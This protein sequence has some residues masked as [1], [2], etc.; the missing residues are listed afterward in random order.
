MLTVLHVW[1]RRT[2]NG[3]RD[4]HWA[5]TKQG[6]RS[7]QCVRSLETTDPDRDRMPDTFAVRTRRSEASASSVVD[8][9]EA[10]AWR[11]SWFGF[12]R[13]VRRHVQALRPDVLH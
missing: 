3:Q 4:L 2:A 9:L 8:R 5:L 7:V 6:V 1:D 11:L 13:F 10:R 12:E